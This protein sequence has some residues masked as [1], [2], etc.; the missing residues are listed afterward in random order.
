MVMK[1]INVTSLTRNG[2]RDWLVQRITSLVLA[3][4]ILFLLG[5]LIFTPDI[6]FFA[7]Q[8]LFTNIYMQVFTVL[9]LLSLVWH[10]W[11]GMWTIATDYI[12]P[13]CI[14]LAFV[15]LMIIALFAYFVWGL[16]ILWGA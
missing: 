10:A 1:L 4:Y 14:R 13:Y 12:K 5:F 8:G 2:V 9:A 15:V 11:I 7:W 3:A 6:G 16:I